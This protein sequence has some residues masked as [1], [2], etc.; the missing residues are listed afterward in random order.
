MEVINNCGLTTSKSCWTKKFSWIFIY[1]YFLVS[2]KTFSF[3][4]IGKMFETGMCWLCHIFIYK[5]ARG[6][7]CECLIFHYTITFPNSIG[8]IEIPRKAVKKKTFNGAITITRNVSVLK[9]LFL[10]S[11]NWEFLPNF[12]VCRFSEEFWNLYSAKWDCHVDIYQRS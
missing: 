10:P 9:I 6:H 4:F 8:R 11:R 1:Q 7:A 5:V 12:C 3:S 2:Q